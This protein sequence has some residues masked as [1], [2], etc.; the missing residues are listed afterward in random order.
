MR[1]VGRDHL[2]SMCL[3]LM[4]C[5]QTYVAALFSALYSLSPRRSAARKLSLSPRR[6]RQPLNPSAG[7]SSEA[8]TRQPTP[9]AA[10]TA[11]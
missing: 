4:F 2:K 3:K 7:A 1:A 5:D 11:C 6:P 10:T 8:Q 9:L